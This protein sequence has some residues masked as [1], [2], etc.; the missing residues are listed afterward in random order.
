MKRG[1]MQAFNPDGK[2]VMRYGRPVY[3][4]PRRDEGRQLLSLRNAAWSTARGVPCLPPDGAFVKLDGETV[5]RFERE[6][7]LDGA[8]VVATKAV[9]V[10]LR[11]RARKE[12][13]AERL[14]KAQEAYDKRQAELKARAKAEAK[15]DGRRSDG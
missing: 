3:A 6:P 9:W 4:E 8:K 1:S 15:K 2:P 12:A 11:E 7:V 13:E 14:R 5:Y 10:D